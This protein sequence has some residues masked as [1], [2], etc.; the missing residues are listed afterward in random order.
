[1]HVAVKRDGQ[2]PVRSIRNYECMNYERWYGKVVS[3]AS[4]VRTV[5]LLPISL[6]KE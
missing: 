2:Y 6:I 5:V 3:R 1:V 4:K